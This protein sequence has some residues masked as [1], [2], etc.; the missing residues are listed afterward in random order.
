LL[1][2]GLCRFGLSLLGFSPLAP[3]LFG[4]QDDQTHDLG[5][6]ETLLT[7]SEHLLK[8]YRCIEDKRTLAVV[9]FTVRDD[10][11][12][13]IPELMPVFILTIQELVLD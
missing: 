7:V 2:L 1:L 11:V 3:I 6:S 10:Q 12:Q 5:A 13:V 8:L 4:S 9:R